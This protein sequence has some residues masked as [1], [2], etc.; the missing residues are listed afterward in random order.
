[1]GNEKKAAEE[2]TKKFTKKSKEIIEIFSEDEAWAEPSKKAKWKQPKKV[3][4]VDGKL[5]KIDSKNFCDR[6]I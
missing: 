5:V 1:M 3:H 4:G 6:C 2:F